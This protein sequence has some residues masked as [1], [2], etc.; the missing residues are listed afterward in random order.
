MLVSICAVVLLVLASLSN[1]VG[2]Q[3]T[4]STVV[5]DSPLFKT[6]TQRATNQQQNILTSQYLGKGNGNLLRFP[7]RDNQ[8]ET[9]KKVI[10]SI[11]KMDDGTFERFT[12]LCIQKTRQDITLSDIDPNE[13]K[14][15]LQILRTQPDRINLNQIR[16]N[17]N[18]T[19]PTIYEY[20]ICNWIPGCVI[21]HAFTTIFLILI[22]I[23][24]LISNIIMFILN[25]I[26]HPTIGCQPTY[27]ANSITYSVGYNMKI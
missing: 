7:L 17:F 25:I 23:F 21:Y 5:N 10:E 1:V 9:L 16:N 15:M 6:R 11:K 14:Q 12:Q 3:S 8:I 18:T 13:I 19:S 27:I 22:L 4:K 26:L 24:I 20:S 2:Y